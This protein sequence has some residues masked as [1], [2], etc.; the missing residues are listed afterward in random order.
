MAEFLTILFTSFLLMSLAEIGDK[1]N[2]ILISMIGKHKKPWTVFSGGMT[3]I[4]VVTVIGA[5][6]GAVI[7]QVL[8]AWLV[9]IISGLVFLYLGISEF[10]GEE[11]EEE[12]IANNDNDLSQFDIYKKA[13]LLIGLAEFGDKSQI[14]VISSAA[15]NDPVAVAIGAILGMFFISLLATL[16]GN[17]LMRRVPEEKLNKIAAILFIVAGLWIIIDAIIDLVS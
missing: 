2:L 8:P 15:I 10:M 1:T 17:T 13:F 9:P 4:V 6:L 14:F 16:L 5:I 7:S 3:G 12:E 11:E